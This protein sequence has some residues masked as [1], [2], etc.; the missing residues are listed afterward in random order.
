[1]PK[2]L[3]QTV[4]MRLKSSH[5]I[6]VDFIVK[7]KLAKVY[8]QCIYIDVF[9]LTFLFLQRK[10]FCCFIKKMIFKLFKNFI[11]PLQLR[12][13]S[14]FQTKTGERDA[15]ARFYRL[16]GQMYFFPWEKI[17]LY[18]LCFC[19]SVTLTTEIKILLCLLPRKAEGRTDS[20]FSMKVGEQ[21]SRKLSKRI[22]N[23][24]DWKNPV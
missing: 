11:I 3:L 24:G 8:E 21:Y 22:R 23:L 13:P 16:V 15:F 9:L 1:M 14:C 6:K 12:V 4:L 18:L 10:M 5:K 7:L 20:V 17:M 19:C 2:N